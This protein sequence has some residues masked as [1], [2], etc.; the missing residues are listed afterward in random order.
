VSLPQVVSHDQ[1]MAARRELL[2]Q[3]E[4]LSRQQAALVA[5]RSR[6]P[7]VRVDRNYVFEGI[8]GRSSL[9]GLFGGC[10]QLVVFHYMF[11]PAWD[12]ACPRCSAFA[13]E[14]SPGLLARLRA[15]DTAFAAVSRAPL[16]KLKASRDWR[17][18]DFPWYSSYRSDF[19]YD[20]HVTL[21][22]RVAPVIYNFESRDEILSAGSP[23]ELLA[24]GIPVEVAGLSCF[25][26]DDG[27]V[28]HTYSSYDRG[29]EALDRA[30]SLLELTVLGSQPPPAFGLADTSG[31]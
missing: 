4:Q 3:E 21:D 29:V 30:R 26:Q 15:R 18:W 5:A 10:R 6:L 2:A 19:N 13:D 27:N 14:F 23:D 28:F 22:E 24:S 16:A 17:P 8:H 31:R 25:V 1:W 12:A 11:D 7:M 20:F 9:S